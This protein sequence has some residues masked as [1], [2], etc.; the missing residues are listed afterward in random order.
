MNQDCG[1]LSFKPD[2]ML[3]ELAL[4]NVIDVCVLHAVDII[5]MG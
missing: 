2:A 4:M 5:H 1:I 3:N